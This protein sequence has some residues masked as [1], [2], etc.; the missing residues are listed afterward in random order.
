MR[1][2]QLTAAQDDAAMSE[3][4]RPRLEFLPADV[5]RQSADEPA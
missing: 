3:E 1:F 2:H 5:S 4:M